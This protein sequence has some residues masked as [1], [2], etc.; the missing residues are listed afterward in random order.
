MIKKTL[1]KLIN[2][3][4]RNFF[5]KFFNRKLILIGNSHILNFR[6]KYENIKN[7]NELDYKVFSQNGE[8]GII[9]YLLYNLKIENPKFIEIGVE[10]Y[11]EANTRFLF[12]T[13]N[14]KGLIIDCIDGFEEKV[15]K[16][17]ILWKGDLKIFKEFITSKN[18][19][20]VL[21][22]FDFLKKIDLF[23]LDVDG[24]DYWIIKN[25]PAKFSKVVVL[26][27]NSNFGPDLEIT[28]PNIEKFNRTKYHYSNLCFGASIKA[29]VKLMK[30]KGFTFV[31]TN[32][33]C[34]NAFFVVDDELDK[35]NIDLPNYEN[36]TK[37]TNS[38]IRESRSNDGDL[39][40]LSGVNKLKEI[41]ECEVID[42]SN[43]ENKRTKIKNIKSLEWYNNGK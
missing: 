9:D 23:S 38:N 11:N 29:L 14:G 25:L 32:K 15:K 41:S 27:Y 13:T 12:E 17:I 42:L 18:I 28:V 10:D 39:N 7:L 30:S 37:Y 43:K 8:D 19:I 40:Y 21:E 35:I 22:K 34:V 1:E 36:L 5:K 3:I 33:S 2:F 31:G 24:I 26:E 6:N 20:N 16:N 4:E